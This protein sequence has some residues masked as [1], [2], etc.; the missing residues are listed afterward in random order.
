[1]V[2]QGATHLY[3]KY[4]HPVLSQYDLQAST[5]KH[6]PAADVRPAV[7]KATAFLARTTAEKR[8]D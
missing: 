7:D 3:E 8:A 1:V 6:A 2:A 4:V 5:S